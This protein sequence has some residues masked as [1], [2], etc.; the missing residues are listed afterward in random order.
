MPKVLVACEG[1][2]KELER[3]PSHIRKHVYCQDCRGASGR[4]GASAD[5]IEERRRLVMKLHREGLSAPEIGR[6]IG[7]HKTTVLNDLHRMGYSAEA[8]RDERRRRVAELYPQRRLAE[9]A[10]ELGCHLGTVWN[11]LVEMGIDRERAGRR[12]VYEPADERVC[13][14]DGCRKPFTPA[15]AQAAHDGWGRF[16]TVR[17]RALHEWATGADKCRAWLKHSPT[18][19][20]AR[21][22]WFGRWAARNPPGLGA[23]PR[24]RRPITLDEAVVEEIRTLSAQGWGRRAISNRLLVSERAVR[25]ILAN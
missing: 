24:G 7:V 22:R 17:C 18:S 16:C 5:E 14:R 19:G 21:Q 23:F 20:R 15:A 13:E 6:R 2:G 3:W 12:S 4:G 8:E 25:N 9:I 10:D 11:D 1:C